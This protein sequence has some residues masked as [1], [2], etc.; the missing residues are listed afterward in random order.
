MRN[1]RRI[2]RAKH[3]ADYVFAVACIL[4]AMIRV[5]IANALTSSWS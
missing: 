1:A 5:F 3:L 4:M 2:H